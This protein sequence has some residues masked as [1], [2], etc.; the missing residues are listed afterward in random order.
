M[1]TYL[2]KGADSAAYKVVVIEDR[3]MTIVNERG[4]QT[5]SYEFID[6]STIRAHP[7]I[8]DALIVN[9]ERVWS[10]EEILDSID[11]SAP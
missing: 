2:Y 10:L 9:S 8:I 6:G 5:P 4:E 3:S 1:P 7:L 11:R